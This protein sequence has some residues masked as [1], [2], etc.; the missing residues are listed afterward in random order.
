MKFLTK[1]GDSTFGP[2][3]FIPVGSLTQPRPLQDSECDLR[4]NSAGRRLAALL[5]LQRHVSLP[6]RLAEVFADLLADDWPAIRSNAAELLSTMN[7]AASP[8]VA[9]LI[10]MTFDSDE[11]NRALA[12]RT[13]SSL[14]IDAD[15][16]LPAARCLLPDPSEDV[17]ELAFSTI[18]A[19][20]RQAAEEV[21]HLIPLMKAGRECVAVGA[22]EALGEIGPSAATAIDHL[23]PIVRDNQW[24]QC[25]SAARALG[26]IGQP[27]PVVMTVLRG[28]LASDITELQLAA[29]TALPQLDSSCAETARYLLDAVQTG[30]PHV[31]MAATTALARHGMHVDVVVRSCAPWVLTAPV[32]SDDDEDFIDDDMYDAVVE[33]LE[34]IGLPGV[35]PTI[36]LLDGDPTQRRFALWLL[37]RIGPTANSA[38]Q[39]VRAQLIDSDPVIRFLAG[40][41]L[42]NTGSPANEAVPAIVEVLGQC[43]LSE[44]G[45]SAL[46]VCPLVESCRGFAAF[47]LEE[48]ESI[49][50]TLRSAVRVALREIGAPAAQSMVDIGQT[51]PGVLRDELQ[52]VLAAINR[53]T[54][55]Q[56]NERGIVETLASRVS[57]DL[58]TR[59]WLREAIGFGDEWANRA[60]GHELSVMSLPM[61]NKCP[62]DGTPSDPPSPIR[63][64][65]DL[66][67]ATLS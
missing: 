59:R 10:D 19:Y 53:D 40:V 66:L 30:E 44:P 2:D 34:G 16:V 41:A 20:G 24:P 12:L 21:E 50:S 13:L 3:G 48:R 58:E 36:E 46:G 5:E 47:F 27:T 49:D 35:G 18:G 15:R 32:L 22:I 14:R 43:D 4:S 17:R 29:I 60:R 8:F 6:D 63:E 57:C 23:V 39:A 64:A 52:F 9:K 31:A 65:V 1:T 26:G 28:A 42:W 67:V 54:I 56:A 45:L 7:G 51:A 37:G 38:R 55:K 33:V 61:T 62:D 25:V 11:A